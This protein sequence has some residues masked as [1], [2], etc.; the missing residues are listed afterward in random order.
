[1]QVTVSH[2]FVLVSQ[3][4]SKSSFL[5]FRIQNKLSLFPSF[6]GLR[7]IPFVLLRRYPYFRLLCRRINGLLLRADDVCGS[8][9]VSLF[10]WPD[11]SYGGTVEDD[12]V[13]G[14][15]EIDSLLSCARG[16]YLVEDVNE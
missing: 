1:M 7:Q 2:V 3:S 14:I 13:T 11:E 5:F 6:Q 15:F 12:G 10:V 16:M 8:N 9:G 4:S